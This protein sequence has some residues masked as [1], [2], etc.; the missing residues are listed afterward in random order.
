[1]VLMADDDDDNDDDGFFLFGLATVVNPD[2]L[3]VGEVFRR[4]AELERGN[5]T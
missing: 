4:K 5:L 2:S 3:P 1:M